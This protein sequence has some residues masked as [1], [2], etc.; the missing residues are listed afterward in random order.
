MA[1]DGVLDG[2]RPLAE[3]LYDLTRAAIGEATPEQRAALRARLEEVAG[4]IKDKPL[5]TEYRRALLDRFFAGRR[6]G[7]QA[8]RPIVVHRP[9]PGPDTATAERCRILVAILLRHP[10]LLHD[11]EEA[12]GALDLS[13][14]LARLRRAILS[15]SVAAETLDSAGLMA[16]LHM[17]GLATEAAQVV[18]AVPMPLPAC[19]APDAQPADAEEG[20]WHIFG[21]MHRSR[22]EEEVAAANRAFTAAGDGPAHRRLIALCRAHEALCHGEQGIDAEQ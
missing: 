3:A 19:A 6:R 8:A 11:V 20:W 22:L 5:A 16:H 12:F 13:P 9:V 17:A 4:R 1:F 18:S 15:W 14:P 10:T 21:L 7:P 2:A